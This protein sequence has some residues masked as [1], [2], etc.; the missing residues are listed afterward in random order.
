MRE[1][2]AIQAARPNIISADIHMITIEM[3]FKNLLLMIAK[4]EYFEEQ[5]IICGGLSLT[6][7]NRYE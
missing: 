7:D 6:A 3:M 1:P 2:M 5:L 4:V